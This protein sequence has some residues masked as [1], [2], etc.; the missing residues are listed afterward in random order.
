MISLLSRNRAVADPL[1]LPAPA[2]PEAAAGIALIAEM[3]TTVNCAKRS[4]WV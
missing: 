4:R 2:W 3:I 1:L